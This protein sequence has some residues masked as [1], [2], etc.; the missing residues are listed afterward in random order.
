MGPPFRSEGAA[1]ERGCFPRHA[2]E[3]PRRSCTSSILE[4]TPRACRR[5]P[6]APRPPNRIL[7]VLA[8]LSVAYLWTSRRVIPAYSAITK[9]RLVNRNRPKTDPSNIW[10]R[11]VPRTRPGSGPLSG[12]RI[13]VRTGHPRT[14]G[15]I[16]VR[17]AHLRM[18]RRLVLDHLARYSPPDG[19]YRGD[20]SFGAEHFALTACGLVAQ[21][22][23]KH[24]PRAPSRTR[25]ATMEH[26][27]VH[28]GQHQCDPP[29]GDNDALLRSGH[30]RVS[31]A[32]S[33]GSMPGR[34]R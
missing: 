28:A 17:T 9:R 10:V 23:G 24:R 3:R 29:G 32:R 16:G 21:G 7:L 6:N 8:E 15:R 11:C 33:G 27:L 4:R 1:Q 26:Q 18:R 19:S 20:A 31:P 30:P 22:T 12:G 13:G 25:W 14:R 5:L 34:P 2:R